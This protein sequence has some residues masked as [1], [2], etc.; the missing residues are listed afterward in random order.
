M[1]H[2]ERPEPKVKQHVP[3]DVL[4][5]R[6]SGKP[7]IP[8]LVK[9]MIGLRYLYRAQLDPGDRVVTLW[10]LENLWGKQ[11]DHSI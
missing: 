9:S 4:K 10:I 5:H 2:T 7:R 6:A 1:Q 8:G 3:C 11:P